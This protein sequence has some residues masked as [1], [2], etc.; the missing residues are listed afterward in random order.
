MAQEHERS[1]NDDN[2][3]DKENKYIIM[4]NMGQV[5]ERMIIKIMMMIKIKILSL[6][7][8]IMLNMG[9]VHERRTPPAGSK[10]R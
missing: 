9:Q 1:I 7:D 2:G 10:L 4:L 6:K 3:D 5:H 8:I